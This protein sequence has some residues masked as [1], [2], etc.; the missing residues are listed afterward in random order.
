MIRCS[1]ES[2]KKNLCYKNTTSAKPTFLCLPVSASYSIIFLSFFIH[3]HFPFRIWD[4][5][6]KSFLCIALKINQP[7]LPGFL[8]LKALYWYALRGEE[9]GEVKRKPI[10]MG[11]GFGM[12]MM[13]SF[14]ISHRLMVGACE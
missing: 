1:K 10:F 12:M 3:P 13:N 2:P 4:L 8:F 9:R 14:S 7:H 5:G 6:N 11:K